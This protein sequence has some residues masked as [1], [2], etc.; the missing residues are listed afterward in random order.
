MSMAT[1]PELVEQL[2]K[3]GVETVTAEY[4]GSGDDGQ[5]EDPQFG[6]AEISRGLIEATIYFFYDVLEDQFSGWENNDGGFGQFNWDVKADR[7]DLVHN[8]NFT[9]HETEERTL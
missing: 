4:N 2:R 7:I 6:S 5:I 8:T 9:D 3:L 1:R